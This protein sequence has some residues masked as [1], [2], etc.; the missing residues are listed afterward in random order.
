[1]PNDLYKEE[2]VSDEIFQV[3]KGQYD[4]DELD[5]NAKQESLDDGSTLWTLE[6]ISVDTPYGNDRMIVNLFL[7]INASPPYQT[8]I[9]FPGSASIYQS[10]SEKIDEYYE[11]PVFLS[12]L[13]KTGRAVAYPVYQGTFE[14]HDDRLAK[15]IFAGNSHA[16]TEFVIEVVKDFRRTID[17]LETREDI[18]TE[19]LAFY[20]M[21]WGST[22]GGI[23]AAVETRL[24]TAIVMGGFVAE[25]RPES[26]MQN[27]APR[28]TMP[29]LSLV[30]RYDSM[31]AYETST[32]PLFDFIGTS[33]DHK[34]MKVYETDHIPPKREYIAEI[35]AWLDRYLGPVDDA[36]SS[37]TP[38]AEE[39]N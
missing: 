29:I 19:R 10:S 4:Y 16:Y 9:Y 6:R 13:V 32:K 30:G 36:S 23:I 20:G 34:L 24:K 31:T 25:G 14:R 1:L 8:V 3:F 21:S 33:D 17:Y 2:I 27:Y 15:T 38:T 28:V 18:D 35:L 7:P 39:V 5:L 26:N 37:T 22:M 12:F 11:F